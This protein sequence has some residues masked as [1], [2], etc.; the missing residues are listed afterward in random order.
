MKDRYVTLAAENQRHASIAR[1]AMTHQTVVVWEDYRNGYAQIYA[2]LLD[3]ANGIAQWFPID[4]V[5][6]STGTGHEQRNPRAVYDSLG[7]VIVAWED[8]RNDAS[9]PFDPVAG[10]SEIYANRLLLTTGE[11][12]PNWNGSVK[13]G[14]ATGYRAE[15]PRLVGAGDGAFITWT[16]Y[17]N[18]GGT[19]PAGLDV[20]VNHIRSADGGAISGTQWAQFPYGIS[21]PAVTGNNRRKSEIIL[22]S[23][24]RSGR[25]G[26]FIVYE[27]DRDTVWQIYAQR[28]AWDGNYQGTDY[29]VAPPTYLRRTGQINPRVVAVTPVDSTTGDRGAVIVWQDGRDAASSGWDIW[30]QAVG[31][32]DNAN[33]GSLWPWTE[34]ANRK[35]GAVVCAY[36]D[37]QHDPALDAWQRYAAVAWEDD[38]DAAGTGMNIY[39]NRLQVYGSGAGTVITTAGTAICTM[40]E[41]QCDPVVEIRPHTQRAAICWVDPR[42]Y[43]VSDTDIYLQQMNTEDWTELWDTDGIAVTKA[44]E[45]QVEPDLGCDVVTFTDRRRVPIT[46]DLQSDENVYAEQIGYECDEPTNMHWK[47][48]LAEWTPGVQAQQQRMA[49]D[50]EGNAYVVWHE[51]RALPAYAIN[52][53]GIYIQK[54]DA[55]GVPRWTNDGVLLSDATLESSLPDVCPDDAGGAIVTWQEI[56]NDRYRVAIARIN[57][58]ESIAWMTRPPVILNGTTPR[59]VENDQGGA[60][61]A[62]REDIWN[63]ILVFGV[64]NI[65]QALLPAPFVQYPSVSTAYLM[66]PRIA[67]DG[68]GGCFVVGR[69]YYW[70]DWVQDYRW[71]IHPFFD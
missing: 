54:L 23:V 24:Y 38:R 8:Y 7:G 49:I 26:A 55:R 10:T 21:P 1:P 18:V 62:Y 36:T 69:K 47:D 60:W 59:I 46:D 9:W 13:A 37:D 68:L 56:F 41:N 52:A 25:R 63:T 40:Q 45:D 20:C 48:V 16:D 14:G 19:P 67:K 71:S 33:T 35:Y 27:D 32:E 30:A 51:N 58:D 15:R 65:G 5:P 22:D 6:V 11:Q 3:S 64:D 42:D 4:G 29:A 28:Y 61:V 70:D 39:G 50:V 57:S 2:Q 12:D 17:R 66:D 44:F 31:F 53:P 43:A 34:P